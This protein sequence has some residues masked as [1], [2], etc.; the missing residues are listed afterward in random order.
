M[1]LNIKIRLMPFVKKVKQIWSSGVTNAVQHRKFQKREW[2]QLTKLEK[3]YKRSG[4]HKYLL[5]ND[6][7][8][9]IRNKFNGLLGGVLS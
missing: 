1:P 6:L 3:Q 9:A 2:R 5:F 8:L 7:L 4:C